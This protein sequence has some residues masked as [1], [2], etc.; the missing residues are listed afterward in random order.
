M[1]QLIPIFA[2]FAM[3]KFFILDSLPMEATL[4]QEGS[5]TAIYCS[6]AA[7]IAIVVPFILKR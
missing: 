3:T 4:T 6:V 5:I 2:L 7:M 1:K